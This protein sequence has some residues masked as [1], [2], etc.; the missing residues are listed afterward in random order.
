MERFWNSAATLALTTGY[1]YCASTAKYYGCIGSLHLNSQTLDRNFH[2][3][4]YDGFLTTVFPVILLL[5]SLA[6]FRLL[7]SHMGLPA[8]IDFFHGNFARKRTFAKIRRK[9]LGKR[10]DTFRERTAKRNTWIFVITATFSIVGIF[11][12][13]YFE[14]R[15]VAEAESIKMAVSKGD[16]ESLTIVTEI[17]QASNERFVFLGCGSELCAVLDPDS[18]DIRY[19]HP[20]DYKFDSGMALLHK[21]LG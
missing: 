10:S 12:L 20:Q 21:S 14:R 3:I 13:A 9:L 6:V 16:L 1:L 4:L 2:Q 11:S 17:N 8:F 7:Y 5:L 15:G 18:G 19:M